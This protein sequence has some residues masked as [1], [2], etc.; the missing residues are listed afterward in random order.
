MIKELLETRIRPAVMEDGGDIVFQV[1]ILCSIPS[2]C[3]RSPVSGMLDQAEGTA[4]AQCTED[5]VMA[6]G[7]VVML[8]R[9]C[10]SRLARPLSDHFNDCVINVDT[11]SCGLHSGK[12][13][14]KSQSM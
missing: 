3:M 5:A 14:L 1:Q 11:C 2:Q 10:A 12:A 9:K 6:G 4:T 13:L 8:G 7:N